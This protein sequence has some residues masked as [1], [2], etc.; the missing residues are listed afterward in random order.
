MGEGGRE[1]CLVVMDFGGY[2]GGEV[3]LV[4]MLLLLLLSL[5]RSYIVK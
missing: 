5:V 1:T 3:E 2:G 4:L